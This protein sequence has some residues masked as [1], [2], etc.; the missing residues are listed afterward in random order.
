MP[1]HKT[2][3]LLGIFFWIIFL[4]YLLLNFHF[5]IERLI[6]LGLVGF[7]FC[8]TGASLPDVDHKKSKAFKRIRFLIGILT[9]VISF[10]MLSNKFDI[11]RIE[12]IAYLLGV[13]ALITFAVIILVLYILM[14][15]HR[16]PLHR[17]STGAVYA[18]AVLILG[19]VIIQ[20][21][22]IAA[23]LALLSFFS[24]ASHI[25]LDKA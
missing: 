20:N 22:E 19:Y 5:K 9:F 25:I 14:P 24:F 18:V 2:H 4:I 17:F 12:G 13:C 8:F 11:N 10:F 3:E 21:L 23:V 6:F 15:H 7:V 1:R 16:G